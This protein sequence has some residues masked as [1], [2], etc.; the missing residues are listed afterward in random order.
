[1]LS[2]RDGTK[3]LHRE[4]A[5]ILKLYNDYNNDFYYAALII[6]VECICFWNGGY[7]RLLQ[8]HSHDLVNV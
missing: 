3:E 8:S 5:L 2:T 6:E 7:G 4:T 1:M